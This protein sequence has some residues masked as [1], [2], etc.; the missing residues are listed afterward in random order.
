MN[1]DSNV[2]LE[3][4]TDQGDEDAGVGMVWGQELICRAR[5]VLLE[6]LGSEKVH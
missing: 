6:A 1:M 2:S 5:S 3:A 4:L